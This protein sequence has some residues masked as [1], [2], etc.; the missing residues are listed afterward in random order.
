MTAIHQYGAF[1]GPPATSDGYF[2][3]AFGMRIPAGG[4][5]ADTLALY[6][7]MKTATKEDR[8]NL[9]KFMRVCTPFSRI[10]S[11]N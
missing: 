3:T 7:Y 11:Y 5:A 1:L 4:V 9:F 6:P 8:A 2:M 10:V